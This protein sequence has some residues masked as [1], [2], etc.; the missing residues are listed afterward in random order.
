MRVRVF[1]AVL[2]SVAITNASM[3]VDKQQVLGSGS[4]VDEHLN[5]LFTQGSV[6]PA[7]SSNG[8]SLTDLLS[9]D[10]RLSLFASYTRDSALVSKRFILPGVKTAVFAPIDVAIKS[11]ARLPHR[12]EAQKDDVTALDAEKQ[13]AKHLDAW[14]AR[15]MS[16]DELPE[17]VS[18]QTTLQ[19]LVD[20]KAI[21]LSREG[22]DVIVGP[23][24][25]KVIDRREASDGILLVIDAVLD[26]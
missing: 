17:D 5:S 18:G 16:S 1:C 15:H 20:G 26:F 2:A 4:A 13:A 14:T 22:D 24:G 10:R 9:T 6:Q 12:G 11:M 25:A 8:P 7:V 23:G 19:S 3:R 21:T